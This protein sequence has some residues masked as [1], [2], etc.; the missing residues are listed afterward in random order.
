MGKGKNVFFNAQ[1]LIQFALL[2]VA[3]ILVAMLSTGF[4]LDW[5]KIDEA[6]AILVAIRLAFTIV[7]YNVVFS[8]D[9]INRRKVQDTNY[10]VTLATNK[11]KIEVIYKN[12]LFNELDTAI[13]EE[14]KE[15]FIKTC[16]NLIRSVSSRL[17]Y[18][19]ICTI[20]EEGKTVFKDVDT[21]LKYYSLSENK[22]KQLKIVLTKITDGDVKF[23]EIEADDILI[24]RDEKGDKTATMKF[25]YKA[26]LFKKNIVK[27]VTFFAT[28]IVMTI[29]QFTG[30]M[31]NFWVELFKNLTLLLGGAVS[32][33]MLSYTYVKIR[34]GVFD[35]KNKFL[36]KRMGIMD[37]YENQN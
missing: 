26:F 9:N 36:E 18:D 37:K 16:N 34:T 14:N 33:V 6:F 3:F 15:R 12:K 5:D 30:G 28:S 27:A 4:K 11:K 8:I 23:E 7:T 24:D 20:N 31:A 2:I 22:A 10:Y 35:Q 1:T 25:N 29:M 17:S 21:L 13:K 19:D 32:A